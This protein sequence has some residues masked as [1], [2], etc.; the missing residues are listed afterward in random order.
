MPATSH[1]VERL[2]LTFRAEKPAPPRSFLPGGWWLW[3]LLGIGFG[4]GGWLISRQ[5]LAQKLGEQLVG[6]KSRPEAMLAIEGLILL[7]STAS[8]EIVAGLQNQDFAV[9][10]TAFR[11]IESQIQRWQEF[12][13][14]ESKSRMQSLAQSLLELPDTTPTDN[15][16]LASSLA[17]RMF[18]ICLERED[19]TLQPIMQLCEE[20][21]Q[22][23]GRGRADASV[24]LIAGAPLA[25]L[26]DVSEVSRSGEDTANDSQYTD[27]QYTDSQYSGSPLTGNSADPPSLPSPPLPTAGSQLTQDQSLESDLQAEPPGATL[28]DESAMPQRN[29]GSIQP[30]SSTGGRASLRLVTSP[31]QRLPVEKPVHRPQVILP[32]E[33]APMELPLEVNAAPE[34]SIALPASEEPNAQALAGI[35][36]LPIQ[37][38]VRLLASVQPK[39]AQAAALA[40]R[41]QGMSDSKLELAM[42]LATGTEEHR[43]E[44]IDGFPA[45]TDID[46]RVWLLWMAQ[47]GQ[48]E[49][50]GRAIAQLSSMLDHDVMRELR[51]LLNRERDPQIAQMIRRML[52]SP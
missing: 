35:E 21:I 3:C 44:V 18:T 47:D 34:P 14:S 23:V 52:I 9:A 7:D 29:I 42:E 26:S 8:K 37:E 2:S 25:D 50:R 20:V 51:L 6:A 41:R 49:V 31:G 36:R 19:Q 16:I 33:Q 40:L 28:L 30:L 4:L 32:S 24:P 38:L 45:R 13:P 27:P 15:F 10:R 1:Q 48:T 46:P 39:I 5:Y 11:A 43:L 22:R 12:K 17:S